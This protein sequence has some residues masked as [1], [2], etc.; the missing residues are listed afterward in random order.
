VLEDQY[1]KC[2]PILQVIVCPSNL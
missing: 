1:R 2:L